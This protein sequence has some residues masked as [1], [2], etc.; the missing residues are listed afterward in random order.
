M[1]LERRCDGTHEHEEARGKDCKLAEDYT[2]D[3][4]RQVHLVLARTA[5]HSELARS[6]SP[7]PPCAA[8]VLSS[9]CDR[10]RHRPPPPRF[11]PLLSGGGCSSACGG[12]CAAATTSWALPTLSAEA[13]VTP[14]ASAMVDVDGPRA[15]AAQPLAYSM[16]SSEED[17]FGEAQEMGEDGEHTSQNKKLHQAYAKI[18]ETSPVHLTKVGKRVDP[19]SKKRASRSPLGNLI[20]GPRPCEPGRAVAEGLPPL[21]VPDMPICASPGCEYF[22]GVVWGRLNTPA[23]I[24][25][26]PNWDWK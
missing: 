4:A 22:A 8:A 14:Q 26:I 23:A 16:D 12:A 24:A 9:Q 18:C 10:G 13:V 2:D 11:R 5:A 6:S 7:N 15:A 21:E 20:L 1:G 25:R 19:C 17:L 3:F